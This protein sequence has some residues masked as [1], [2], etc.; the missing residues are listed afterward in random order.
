MLDKILN[1]SD[2]F[3][4]TQETSE[5]LAIIRSPY[6]GVGEKHHILPVSIFPEY[7]KEPWNIVNLSYAEHYRCHELLPFMVDGRARISMQYAWNHM[8]SRLRGVKVDAAAYAQ[9]KSEFSK[10]VSKQ[11][12][13]CKCPWTTERLLKDNPSKLD[14]VK[15]KKA[16]KWEIYWANPDNI[17]FR[18]E[19]NPNKGKKFPERG[20]A[21]SAAK[22]GRPSGT[23]G[24]KR[25]SEYVT[26]NLL[27]E[28]N[29][30]ARA[31]ICDGL[32]FPTATDAGA[33][34]G[35]TKQAVM[36]WIKKGRF[37][38]EGDAPKEYVPTDFRTSRISVDG[39]EFATMSEAA[40]HFEVTTATLRNWIKSGKATKLPKE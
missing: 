30:M 3:L 17:K 5:Y 31:V 38:Y 4:D 32:R 8:A 24:L 26:N 16:A 7:S 19:N 34:F 11:F 25:S 1:E 20:A 10:T 21:I 9:L 12:K 36:Y 23:K 6:S 40:K 18:A 39:V 27:G 15:Q 33:H 2:P 14:S 22:K 28:K 37:H 35:Y 29:P 13:G